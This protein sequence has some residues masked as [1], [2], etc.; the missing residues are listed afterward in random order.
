MKRNILYIDIQRML[1]NL[2]QFPFFVWSLSNPKQNKI[3]LCFVQL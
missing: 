1:F 3:K 2:L